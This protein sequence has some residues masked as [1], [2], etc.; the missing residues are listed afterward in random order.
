MFNFFQILNYI[1]DIKKIDLTHLKNYATNTHWLFQNKGEHYKLLAF[2]SSKLKNETIFDIGTYEGN[3]ALALALGENK[4]VS[5]DIINC[6]TIKSK[7]NNIEFVI[8]DFRNDSKILSS[9]LIL[10]DVDPHDGIKEKEFHEF[11][12]SNNYK[13]VVLWDDIYFNDAMR[14]WWNSIKDDSVVKFDLSSIGHHS[15]TGMIVYGLEG[16]REPRE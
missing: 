14:N 16:L 9:P 6:R 13:G 10:I 2:L 12:I 8:G 3:S 1:D 5:Y 11:F 4:V 7:P 15:G